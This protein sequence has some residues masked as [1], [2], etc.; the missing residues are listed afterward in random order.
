MKLTLKLMITVTAFLV[1]CEQHQSVQLTIDEE[2]QRAA[3]EHQL[4]G[5]PSTNRDIPSIYDPK[6]Q[7]GMQLF[8]SKALGGDLDS[9]CVTCHHPLL[10]GGDNLSLP[11][12]AGALEV[13]MLGAGRTHSPLSS[14]YDGYAPVRRNAPT[15]FNIALWDSALFWDGRVESLFPVPGFNGAIGGISTPDSG[16]GLADMDA[17]MNLVAAQARFPLTSEE[18]MQGFVFEARQ[19]NAIVRAHLVLRLSDTL[20]SDYIANTWGSAFQSVYGDATVDMEKITDAIAAYERSQLFIESPWKVYLEGNLTAITDSAKRGALL[21]FNTYEEGG[22]DC[23]AC[24]SGDFFT[25]EDFYVMAMPQVG[26]GKYNGDT[27]DDD[28]G[29]SKVTGHN[30]YAFRTPTLLNVEVTGPWGHCGSYT[31][32]EGVVRHMADPEKAARAYDA[33]QLRSDVKTLNT[34]QNTENALQQLK[35]DRL[36]ELT[37][38]QSKDITEEEVDDIVSFLKTLTDPCVKSRAC[39]TPWIPDNTT[40]RDGLQLNGVSLDGDLF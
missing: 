35:L 33:G 11:V 21:F 7:L 27:A 16:T 32:L 9:A 10:G 8:Y 3:D 40:G 34:Y 5:D 6:A 25:D 23:A 24:H 37:P 15:T 39:L 2:I 12:G 31:T 17:G 4:T 36:A 30:R 28:Y 38:H 20:S 14:D 22:F 18:E 13:D 1:G 29:R 26:R 19:S